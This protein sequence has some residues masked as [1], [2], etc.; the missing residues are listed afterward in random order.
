MNWKVFLL[1]AL[2]GQYLTF[3]NYP[4]DVYQLNAATPRSKNLLVSRGSETIVSI[5]STVTME[6]FWQRL[7][8]AKVITYLPDHSHLRRKASIRS[9]SCSTYCSCVVDVC[10]RRRTP[11]TYSRFSADGCIWSFLSSSP[12]LML[13]Y[14]FL[15]TRLCVLFN[16][17][18][19]SSLC[20]E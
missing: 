8:A 7:C 19:K 5:V 2:R 17:T 10:R 11:L 14:P 3:G 16:T 18:F 12:A 6:N 9:A 20:L 13:A 15:Q 1:N 4:K